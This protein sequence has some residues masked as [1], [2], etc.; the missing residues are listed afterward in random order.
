MV[1][2][3]H[4][5]VRIPYGNRHTICPVL[6]VCAMDILIGV[7]PHLFD[8]DFRRR[9]KFAGLAGLDG[10]DGSDD[11]NSLQVVGFDNDR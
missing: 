5:V 4:L 10:L 2:V 3:I 9:V 1:L 8:Q 6:D 7:S 11:F